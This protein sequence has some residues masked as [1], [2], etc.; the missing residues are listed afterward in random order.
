MEPQV[1]RPDYG[2]FRIAEEPLGD[3]AAY[4]EALS[5]TEPITFICGCDTINSGGAVLTSDDSGH[6]ILVDTA[7]ERDSLI[8]VD[9]CLECEGGESDGRA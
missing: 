7:E 1:E 5:E 2:R 4:H 8:E 6:G 3:M 9:S